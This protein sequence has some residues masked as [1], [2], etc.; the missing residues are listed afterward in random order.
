MRKR[1]NRGIAA[2]VGLT[3]AGTGL[4]VTTAVPA[5]ASSYDCPSGYFCGW[6]GE[7]ATGSMW[8]TNKNLAD[9]GSWNDKIRSYVNRTQSIA[10]LYEDKNYDPWGGYWP[11]DPNTPGELASSPD[12]TTS[13]IKFVR[14]EREC[15]QTAYPSWYSD[16]SPTAAGFGD[17]NGDRR[18]DL[19]TRDLAG[20][21][22]FTRATTPA[23]SSVRAAGTP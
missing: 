23:G 12:A 13:S 20:R 10:C 16:P 5:A 19:L 14:T 21:L 1:F 15:S 11:Q 9:L 8:K 6:S 18:A 4:A 17:L 22:W 2:L 3:L 7:S